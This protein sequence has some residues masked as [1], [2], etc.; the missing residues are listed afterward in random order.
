M[1]FVFCLLILYLLLQQNRLLKIIAIGI[2]F[3]L[4]LMHQTTLLHFSGILAGIMIVEFILRRRLQLINFNY[5]VLFTIAYLG[6]WFLMCYPFLNEWLVT[7]STSKVMDIP[8]ATEAARDPLITIIAKNGDSIISLFFVVV[9]IISQLRQDDDSVTRANVFALF[10]LIA[11]PFFIPSIA[12]ALSPLLLAYR[13]ELLLAPFVAY[14]MASGLLALMPQWGINWQRLK[15]FKSMAQSGLMILLVLIFSFSSVF[16]LGMQTDLN[17]SELG[18]METRRYLTEAEL[19]SFSFLANHDADIPIYTDSHSARY[20][21]GFFQRPA[22]GTVD[23]LD[24][25]SMGGG[26]ILFRKETFELRGILLFAPS[27]LTSINNPVY[28]YRIGDKPDIRV[29][30]RQGNKIFENGAVQIFMN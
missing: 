14:A 19:A 2:I 21:A 23:A 4:L 28:E 30:W 5:V 20:L 11:A 13:L 3:P 12:S 16:L 10:T 7:A 15:P 26:Y 25:D 18:A 29:L 9:G 24:T 27:V 1:A 22:N 6:Y 17:V 8:T